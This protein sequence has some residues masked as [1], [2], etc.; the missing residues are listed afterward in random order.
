MC[1]RKLTPMMMKENWLI[2]F[3]CRW[4]LI[5]ADGHWIWTIKKKY[6]NYEIK[7]ET[8]EHKIN[9]HGKWKR[10]HQQPTSFIN[11]YKTKWIKQYEEKN[12]TRTNIVADALRKLGVWTT[13]KDVKTD[14]WQIN[15]L[16]K[17]IKW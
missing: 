10:C 7:S 5:K 14:I 3:S 15:T 13:R 9:K 12:T 1:F 2:I 8:K 16:H 17:N 11:N 4:T 6:C